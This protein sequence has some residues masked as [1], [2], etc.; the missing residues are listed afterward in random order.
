MTSEPDIMK[1]LVDKYNSGVVVGIPSIIGSEMIFKQWNYKFKIGK[2]GLLEADTDDLVDLTQSDILCIAPLVACT[3]SGDRLGRGGGFYDRFFAK[4]P[5]IFKAG[6][7]YK[8]QVL[9]EIP[10]MPYDIKLDR[11]IYF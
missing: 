4:Y 3:R 8:E 7:C 1:F 2:F 11:I 5:Q 6:V 10:T 9:S